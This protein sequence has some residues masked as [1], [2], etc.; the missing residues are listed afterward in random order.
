MTEEEKLEID[1][2]IR[3][4]EDISKGLNKLEKQLKNGKFHASQRD[5]KLPDK[6]WFFMYVQVSKLVYFLNI[7]TK[8][9]TR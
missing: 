8:K 4:D 6:K 5:K 1:K 9:K 3:K 7:Q 2:Q